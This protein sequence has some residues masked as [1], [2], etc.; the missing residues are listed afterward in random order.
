M[1]IGPQKESIHSMKRRAIELRNESNRTLDSK[2][3]QQLRSLAND[4]EQQV[5]DAERPH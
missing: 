1:H 2:R 3:R 4:L 5:R